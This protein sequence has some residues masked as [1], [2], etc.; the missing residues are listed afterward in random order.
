MLK[1]CH[2]NLNYLD[3]VKL[4]NHVNKGICTLGPKIKR[5]KTEKKN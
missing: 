2:S 5:T 3:N 4:C 1:F